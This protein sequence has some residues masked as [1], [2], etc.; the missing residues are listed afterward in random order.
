MHTHVRGSSSTGWHIWG[1]MPFMT[2]FYYPLSWGRASTSSITKTSSL[3]SQDEMQ[4]L[5]DYRGRQFW[6]LLKPP[7]QQNGFSMGLLFSSRNNLRS[8][9]PALV[10][11]SS[12]EGRTKEATK[13]DYTDVPSIIISIKN[14]H[15]PATSVI[16]QQQQVQVTCWKRASL[17][18]THPSRPI[19]NFS[20]GEL[21]I[22]RAA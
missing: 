3:P 18:T 15:L 21:F 13:V 17:V 11:A 10:T 6:P 7:P 22:S 20:S 1:I 5:H 2:E 16:S 4:S 14:T 8:L 12:S 19:R 9:G